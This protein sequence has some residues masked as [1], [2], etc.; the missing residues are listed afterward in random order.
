MLSLFYPDTMGQIIQGWV[1]AY[2]EGGW[3][4][5]V[6]L[7]PWWRMAAIV[8]DSFRDKKSLFYFPS[9]LSVRVSF[10]ALQAPCVPCLSD[11]LHIYSAVGQPRLPRRYGRNDGR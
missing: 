4:P 6:G 5:K 7:A 11:L 2:S 9:F 1:N 10:R 8:A 3:L